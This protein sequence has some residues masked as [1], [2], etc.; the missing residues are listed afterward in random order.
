MEK[1]ISDG[2]WRWRTCG[3]RCIVLCNCCKLNHSIGHQHWSA[4]DK[5]LDFPTVRSRLLELGDDELFTLSCFDLE[6]VLFTNYDRPNVFPGIFQ[7]A[8]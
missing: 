8:I 6:T 3:R 1:A 2:T 5:Y 4:A 7:I